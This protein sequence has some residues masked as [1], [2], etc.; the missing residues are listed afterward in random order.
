MTMISNALRNSISMSNDSVHVLCDPCRFNGK[1]TVA[2]K[3]CQDCNGHLCP[4]CVN[5]HIRVNNT[6]N[7]HLSYIFNKRGGE[8]EKDASINVD[9]AAT[10]NKQLEAKCVEHGKSVVSFCDTH[11][12][13]C[14]RVCIG[15]DHRECK[16]KELS[17]A[18][19]RARD[20]REFRVVEGEIKRLQAR[21][22]ELHR[23]KQASLQHL[24]H[25]NDTFTSAVKTFRR[26]LNNF[27]DKL[28]QNMMKKKDRHFEMKAEEIRGCLKTCQAAISVL[29]GS[30][31]KLD[32]AVKQ[33]DDQPLFMT[34]KKVQAVSH[35][36]DKVYN[37][38]D[39]LPRNYAF[40][41]VPEAVIE[42]FLK[43][44]SDLGL[45][46]DDT[47][48]ASGSPGVWKNKDW[49]EKQ[50]DDDKVSATSAA[51][52]HRQ[53]SPR[54]PLEPQTT[55]IKQPM[56]MGELNVRIPTD[57]KSCSITGAAFLLDDKV[58]V[59]DATNKKVKVFGAD[60]KPYAHIETQTAPRDVTIVSATEV[61]CTLPNDRTVH[62]ITVGKQLTVN[63]TFRLDVECYGICHADGAF[64]VTSGWS[65]DKEVQLID[66]EGVL[67]KKLRP[68]PGVF[69][70]PL[71]VTVHNK[72]GHIY[73]SDYETGI[74]C[75]D[76]TGTVILKCADN[77]SKGYMGICS[78][79]QGEIYICTL[80]PNGISKVHTENKRYGSLQS[81]NTSELEPLITLQT[82][83]KGGQR[84]RSIAY[85]WNKS[86]IVIS[87][88]GQSV[89]VMSIYNV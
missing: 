18:A 74:V 55:A 64:Y 66:A 79:P 31:N 28:E 15:K 33:G 46:K 35:R 34:I 76:M 78:S 4:Y 48:G 16:L 65:T 30:L 47:S 32:I 22:E 70:C 29:N 24:G 9:T 71:Y 77:N 12:A 89:D 83:S 57:K 42:R 56:G 84:P 85:S 39:K 19:S 54:K 59:A 63:K 7:H 51:P 14:C 37:D 26:T 61:A 80:Q 11:D 62:V 73:V 17:E 1:T 72:F 25:Q 3:Y 69:K 68:E 44:V 13:L 60:L 86:K 49:R 81:L 82:L 10:A 23:K 5:T 27:L 43:G 50:D 8:G 45:I 41:F 38:M 36:Y 87:F 21:F 2:I 40:H 67:K 52:K 88:V 75:M 6:K 20:G 53:K 58:V